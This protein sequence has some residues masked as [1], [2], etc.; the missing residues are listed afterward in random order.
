MLSTCLINYDHEA[1][2]NKNLLS[3]RKG[4]ILNKD[5]SA[6][7]ESKLKS[8]NHLNWSLVYSYTKRIDFLHTTQ[9]KFQ[10]VNEVFL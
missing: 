9:L 5:A 1:G 8:K 7:I 2:S 4:L 10:A 3:K 6:G